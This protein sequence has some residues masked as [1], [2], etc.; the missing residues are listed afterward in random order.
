MLGGTFSLA[1]AQLLLLFYSKIKTKKNTYTH[2]QKKKKKKKKKSANLKLSFSSKLHRSNC[3]SKPGQIVCSRCTISP[4]TRLRIT[5]KTTIQGF[6]TVYVCVLWCHLVDHISIC[7]I[8]AYRRFQSLSVISRR[9][10]DVAGSSMLTFRV[11]P[12]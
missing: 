2:I 12:L 10:L 4:F 8:W 1:E 11:L 9:C 5:S 6:F 7:L 3:S